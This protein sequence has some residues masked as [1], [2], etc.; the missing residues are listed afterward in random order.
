MNKIRYENKSM[1]VIIPVDEAITSHL[2]YLSDNDGPHIVNGGKIVH[3]LWISQS[4]LDIVTAH[5]ENGLR[6]Y[7]CKHTPDSEDLNIIVVPVGND[8]HNVL[9]D[10]NG[11]SVLAN[12]LRPCPDDCPPSTTYNNSFSE[13]DLNH[14]THNG[15]K[16]WCKPN[17]KNKG[18][19]WFDKSGN[20]VQGPTLKKPEG[21]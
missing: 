10:E 4:D 20:A 11:D 17:I 5:A 7:F 15:V 6:L 13:K 3:F 9:V 2:N 19:I 16:I 12:T 1:D 8:G 21:V 18:S 14:I